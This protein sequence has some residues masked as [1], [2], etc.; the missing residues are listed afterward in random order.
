[1]IFCKKSSLVLLLLLPA[2]HIL[3]YK[4]EEI[5]WVRNENKFIILTESS[6]MTITQY[7]APSGWISLVIDTFKLRDDDATEVITNGSIG[8][9]T[10]NNLVYYKLN[11][12]HWSSYTSSMSQAGWGRLVKLDCL[13]SRKYLYL[14]KIEYWWSCLL[15]LFCI[16]TLFSYEAVDWI[17]DYLRICIEQT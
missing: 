4:L 6:L 2:N 10:T 1:M 7:G 15:P 13:K 8:L 14:H 16:L 9:L 5:K 11:P 17:D 3:C 12:T